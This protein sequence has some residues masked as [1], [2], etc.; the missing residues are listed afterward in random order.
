MVAQYSIQYGEEQCAEYMHCWIDVY[1]VVVRFELE[2]S[3]SFK[4][5]EKA[6]VRH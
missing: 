6:D 1:D 3:R 4:M 5:V 2:W